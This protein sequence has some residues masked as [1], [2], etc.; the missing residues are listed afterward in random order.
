[1]GGEGQE[2][3]Q[4]EQEDNVNLGWQKQS[5]NMVGGGGRKEKWDDNSSHSVPIIKAENSN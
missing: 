3:R 4:A 2:E 5:E 1:M